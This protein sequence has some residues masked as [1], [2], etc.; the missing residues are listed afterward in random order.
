MDQLENI[1]ELIAKC[2]LGEASVDEKQRMQEWITQSAENKSYYAKCK[3][4][5]EIAGDVLNEEK[6]VE[7][8]FERFNHSISNNHKKSTLKRIST[9][10]YSKAA[11][12]VL[13]IGTIYLLYT[14]SRTEKDIKLSTETA[15]VKK[16]LPDGTFVIL[17]QKSQL[18]YP[19]V[20]NEENREV[21][22][23][24]N[25]YFRIHHNDKL[26]FIINIG[27][28]FIKDVGTS[29][30]VKADPAD[31][32]VQVTVEEG[33]VAFYSL[34]D[35]GIRLNATQTGIYNKYTGRF[36]MLTSE[37]NPPTRKMMTLNFE[38]ASLRNIV[39]EVNK[40]Y[41]STIVLSCDKLDS[42]ELTVTFT[43]DSVEPIV[44]AIAATL[45]LTIKN[46]GSTI[47]LT[48]ASCE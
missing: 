2:E 18:S 28:V 33:I 39:N 25:A 16:L 36:K 23:S 1:D 37:A 21:K 14:F 35:P 3:T 41:H 10:F 4:I 30:N 11:T 29:F 42:L 5:F 8:A 20:F 7:R 38:N 45:G 12:L 15:S 46:E 13:L 34:S 27:N 40:T 48:N 19:A 31:S 22:L 26:P 47:I 17:D 24:G 44:E 32:I 6:K 43:E 9:V